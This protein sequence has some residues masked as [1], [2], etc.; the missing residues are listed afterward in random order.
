MS[1]SEEVVQIPVTSLRA[2]LSTRTR[3]ERLRNTTTSALQK[4]QTSTRSRKARK[5]LHTSI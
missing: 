3:Y 4:E 2:L 1:L 5:P